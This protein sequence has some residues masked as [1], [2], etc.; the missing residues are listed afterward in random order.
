MKQKHKPSPKG[1]PF[2]QLQ[3]TKGRESSLKC[4]MGVAKGDRN[5]GANRTKAWSLELDRLKANDDMH[6]MHVG[7][8]K[9]QFLF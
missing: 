6:F 1:V 5:Y 2:F 7:M 8:K 3:H 4:R 9:V